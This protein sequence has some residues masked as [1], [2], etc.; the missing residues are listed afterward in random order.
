MNSKELPPT[1]Y[2]ENAVLTSSKLIDW[3]RNLTKYN[4]KTLPKTALLTFN[5]NYLDKR[6]RIF[7]KK[8][9]GL[10]GQNYLVN[11]SLLVCTDF[12]FG[13]SAT[14]SLLEEL[15][16]L[17]VENFI[18][19]GFAGS[20]DSS[21]SEGDIFIV[22]QA[23]S[24]TGCTV[25]YDSNDIFGP[26]NSSW[27]SGLQSKLTFKETICWS[28]DAPFRETPELI[29]HFISKKATHVDMECAAIYAFANFY[30]LNALCVIVSAD[31]ISSTN[32]VPPS[33]LFELHKVI[34]RVV[35]SCIKLV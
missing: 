35:Q 11:K 26:N 32:W 34:V 9:K 12:G 14:I 24:T 15:R 2:S 18:F 23:Y 31:T 20:L 6:T 29:S 27:C 28:T 3:K 22:N 17:G 19:I 1:Y 16:G 8:I 4:F 13:A 25:L 33:N 21:I 5:K 7:S 30:Q 10:V